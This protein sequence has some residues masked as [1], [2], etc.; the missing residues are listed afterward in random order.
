MFRILLLFVV[1]VLIYFTVALILMLIPAKGWDYAQDKSYPIYISTNGLH[2]S[3][4]LPVK[5]AETDWRSYFPVKHF[6]GV[7]SN[8]Q[9]ISFGWGDRDFYLNTP[10]WDDLSISTTSRAL[11]WPT[12]SIVQVTY[13]KDYQ[14]DDADCR[15][16]YLSRSQID[17]LKEYIKHTIQGGEQPSLKPISNSGYTRY[18]RFYEANGKYSCLNTC[19]NWLN[20]GLK[21]MGF[22]TSMWSPLDWGIFYYLK[23]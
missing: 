15:K 14:C 21:K 6:P 23:E 9:Y 7:D 5:V 18:D 17:A 13:W 2:A 3:F 19:N 12:R 4:T 1:V 8:F 10:T 11:F 22:K 20:R 16:L